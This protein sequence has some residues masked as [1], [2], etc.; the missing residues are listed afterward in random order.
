MFQSSGGTSRGDLTK[1]YYWHRERKYRISRFL[2]DR[3][4]VEL[5]QILS[6]LNLGKKI[7]EVADEAHDIFRKAVVADIS[8][9]RPIGS[10]IA[11]VIYAACRRLAVPAN[12]NEICENSNAKRKSV[13]RCY[14]IMLAMR[15][16]TVPVPDYSIHLERLWKK[17]DSFGLT[18]KDLT[19]ALQIFRKAKSLGI[20]G[21]RNP[22]SIA[23][24]SI[25]LAC[26]PRLAQWEIAK[27]AGISEVTIRNNC[28]RLKSRV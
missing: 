22:V 12:L 26:K 15:I 2:L 5:N 8:K 19:K 23:A 3:E 21:G 6:K 14:R 24:A 1:A 16:F 18:E 28:K 13:A 4:L 9:G 7:M 27:E 11:A 20:L 10:L 25:Y 17:L